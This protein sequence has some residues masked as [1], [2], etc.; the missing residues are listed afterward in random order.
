LEN[1]SEPMN[2]SSTWEKGY[3]IG[4]GKPP[5]STRFQPGQ[6]GNLKGRPKGSKNSKTLL[7]EALTETV[8]VT[9]GGI[10]KRMT[11]LECVIRALV[12]RATKDNKAA[13][14]VLKLANE[15]ELLKERDEPR[16]MTI[17]LVGGRESDSDSDA[18]ILKMPPVRRQDPVR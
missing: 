14:H 4:H 7:L 5:K 18:T 11:K 6:S 1:G 16:T 2:W 17:R 13:E 12:V 3:E 8:V 15:Y 9:E 10:S